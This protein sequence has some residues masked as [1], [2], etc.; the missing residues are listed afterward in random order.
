MESSEFN[1]SSEVNFLERFNGDIENP[2]WDIDRTTSILVGVYGFTAV[3]VHYDHTMDRINQEVLFMFGGMHEP[4]MGIN[5]DV[6]YING[7][8]P[9][10]K[11]A[12]KLLQDRKE[13]R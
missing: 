13:H 7:M 2:Q 10:Y 4:S 8:G 11:H 12:Q 6:Y 3:A 5:S 1:L 9:P